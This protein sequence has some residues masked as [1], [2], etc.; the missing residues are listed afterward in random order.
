MTTEIGLYY[1]TIEFKND[2]WVK[3]AVL[4]WDK[5]GRIVPSGYRPNDSETVKRLAGELDFIK[6]F[7]PQLDEKRQL[8]NMFISL[9]PKFCPK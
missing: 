3:L 4:Y 9:L 2:A 7:P 5:L 6:D 1:P 8:A